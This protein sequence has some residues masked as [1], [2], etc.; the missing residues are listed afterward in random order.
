MNLEQ[1][2]LRL[3]AAARAES[4]SDRVPYAFEKRLMARLA[5]RSLPDG[6]AAWSALLWR[7]L[8]PCCALMILAGAGS[9]AFSPTATPDLGAE[10]D[11][12]LLADVETGA[13]VP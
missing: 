1:L 5:A 8:A 11:A 6:W 3:I 9:L 7:A 10:L 2:R 13:E 12:V 4:P